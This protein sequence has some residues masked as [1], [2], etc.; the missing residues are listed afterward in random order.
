MDENEKKKQPVQVCSIRIMFPV[1]TDEQAISYKK[2]IGDVLADIPQAR[3]EFSI[4]SRP[5]LTPNG[6]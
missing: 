2:K 6:S 3:I 1:D 5:P 4:M